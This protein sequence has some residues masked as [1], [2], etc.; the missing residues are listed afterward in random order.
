MS[1]F[2]YFKVNLETN[3]GAYKIELMFSAINFQVLGFKLI[4]P[5]P[6]DDSLYIYEGVN[7]SL[8]SEKLKF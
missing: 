8:N 5:K 3:E 1:D 4:T 6:K 7:C 2:K